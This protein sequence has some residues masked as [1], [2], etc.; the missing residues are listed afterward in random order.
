MAVASWRQAS[1]RQISRT[2]D[3]RN[4]F[5]PRVEVLEDRL[6]PAT[7]L[8][9]GPTGPTSV[10]NT[11]PFG[12]NNPSFGPTKGFIYRNIP[13]F[14]ALPGDSIAFDLGAQNNVDIQ[15]EVALV[16]TT[17]NGGTTNAGAFTTIAPNTQVPLN[18]RGDT[19]IGNYELQWTF[20]VP[21]TFAGGGLIVR[22][23]N[24]GGAMA[25]DM[26]SN[27]TVVGFPATDAAGFWV[28]RFYADPDGVAPFSPSDTAVMGG[29]RLILRHTDLEVVSNTASAAT[30]GNNFTYTI[31]ARNNG[32]YATDT[33]TTLSVPLDPNTTYQS[34][35]A[36][37][38]WAI[39]SAPA[40][41]STGTVTFTR[42]AWAAGASDTFSIIVNVNPTTI[43]GTTLS[44]T[45]TISSSSIIELV[46]ANDSRTATTA[47]PA[48][49]LEVVSDTATSPAIAGTDLTYTILARNNSTYAAGGTVTLTVTL[50]PNTTFVAVLNPPGWTATTPAVGS[51]GTVT[52]TRT[53]WAAGAS[54]TFTIVVH[55]LSS[56]PAG[57]LLNSTA[58]IASL[59]I[60]PVPANNSRTATTLVNTSADLVVTKS[61]APDPASAGGPL[62]Y[63]ITV[64]NNGPSD[65]LNVTLTDVLPTG[66]IFVSQEQTAGPAFTLSNIG[67]A[68]SNTA[69]RL[70]AGASATFLVR[71]QVKATAPS[72]AI[73]TNTA[74]VSSSTPD[75]VPGNNTIT[76][77]TTVLDTPRLYAVGADIGGQPVVQVYDAN[78]GAL[79]FVFLAFDPSFRGG[80]RVAV[81]DVTGDGTD[82]IIVGAGPGGGPQV[83]IVDGRTQQVIR[84]F[85]GITPASFQGG[86]FVASGDVDGD[87]FDDVIVGADASGGPQVQ[88]FSGRTG[89]MLKAF[90]VLAPGFQGGVRVGAGDVDG[91]G[92]SDVITGAGPGGLPQVTVYRFRDLAVLQ[93]FWAF[94]GNFGG[95]VYVAGGDLDRDGFAEVIAGAGL[96]GLPQ[97][98]VARGGSSNLAGAFI[99]GTGFFSIGDSNPSARV[100]QASA[101]AR[102][103][104]TSI[105]GRGAI[106]ATPG[107]GGDP[108]VRTYDGQSFAELGAF[109]AFDP[110]FR[111]GLFVG[112]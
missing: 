76:I 65:A 90:S 14:S 105:N 48:A 37:A 59:G 63:T 30:H 80:V 97:I 25:T 13:A 23:S 20:T 93:S 55:I 32:P 45:A 78:S 5:F 104:V 62:A 77:G 86:V 112:G 4:N 61:D 33:L 34:A 107:H 39:A 109:F 58:T 47:V 44:S 21:F 57:T 3:R 99:A 49:N 19:V 52:F 16:A 84:S 92:F 102:V 36:P 103:A 60:D 88:V 15:F 35:V 56:V 10:S 24:A 40:V 71:V 74:T 43:G 41:G 89:D 100:G 68:I 6:A 95:G 67:N 42:A 2:P 75:P 79:R 98:S 94:P 18:P 50:D 7:T 106:L 22:F 28:N 38:G 31:V 82:D 73:L 87:G 91:D 29:F 8:T 1:N 69:V 111:G 27:S 83:V 85:F 17:T 46:P 108:I 66:T 11:I 81:G 72:G 110:S 54:D 26:A 12:D 70:A 64:T 96:G 101:G 51:T 9:F 53:G